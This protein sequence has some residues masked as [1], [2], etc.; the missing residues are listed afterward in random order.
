MNYKGPILLGLIISVATL[1]LGTGCVPTKERRATQEREAMIADR[2]NN[3]ATNQDLKIIVLREHPNERIAFRYIPETQQKG[4]GTVAISPAWLPKEKVELCWLVTSDD[5]VKHFWGEGQNPQFWSE[6]Q[7]AVMEQLKPLRATHPAGAPELTT[8]PPQKD[9]EPIIRIRPGHVPGVLRG[10]LSHWGAQEAGGITS[11][12]FTYKPNQVTGYIAVAGAGIVLLDELGGEKGVT[13]YTLPTG[14]T[15]AL[16]KDRGEA[17]K[18]LAKDVV[19]P[20]EATKLAMKVGQ[21]LGSNV[22]G[23][24]PIK[25]PPWMGH[26]AVST[27]VAV[28]TAP[29]TAPVAVGKTV[30]RDAKHWISK[31]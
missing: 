27:G 15:I 30:V 26:G 23:M 6:R 17:I 31:W 1:F 25:A 11:L 4:E 22:G 2:L 18:N 12:I 19:N 20:V 24:I 5:S 16:P 29:V 8:A 7:D 3:L 28:A 9:K 21:S 10:D 14:Q 13:F